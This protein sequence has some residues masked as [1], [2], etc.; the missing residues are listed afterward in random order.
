MCLYESYVI[1][2]SKEALDIL[3]CLE[4]FI[5]NFSYFL[6]KLCTEENLIVWICLVGHIDIPAAS[7]DFQRE[8]YH[9]SFSSDK[10]KNI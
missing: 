8:F 4:V 10:H 7:M 9:S 2:L 6:K 3:F 5:K 1:T